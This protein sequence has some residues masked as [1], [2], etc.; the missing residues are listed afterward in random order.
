M[1]IWASRE[2]AS[3]WHPAGGSDAP[4]G[5]SGAVAGRLCAASGIRLLTS[6]REGCG[7]KDI[8]GGRPAGCRF[9]SNYPTGVLPAPA[10]PRSHKR[11]GGPQG[12]TGKM[13][14]PGRKRQREGEAASCPPLRSTWPHLHSV[15]VGFNPTIHAPI[16]GHDGAEAPPADSALNG[17]AVRAVVGEVARQFIGGVMASNG[18]WMAGSSPA[19]TVVC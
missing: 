7:R 14:N 10:T 9:S 3:G 4:V 11:R 1:P 19:M 6:R 2:Q 17:L 15:I 18:A 12:P 16:S 13:H 5:E 8:R